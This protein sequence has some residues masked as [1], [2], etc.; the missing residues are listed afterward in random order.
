MYLDNI[1]EFAKSNKMKIN[2]NKTKV[3]KF[4]RA[5]SFDFPLEVSLS[6]KVNLEIVKNIKLLGI[7]ISDKLKWNENT[8]YFCDKARRKI[9]LIRNMKLSGLTENQLLH[10]Y[11]KEVRSLLELA[12]PV[13][14]SGLTIEQIDQIE[15]V[16]KLALS[17]ILGHSYESYERA[18]V[19][20][21]LD[22]L[23]TRRDKLCTKFIRKNL[24]S[25]RPLFQV[26]NK[27]HATRSNQ[28]LLEEIHCRTQA[29]FDSGLPYLTR[30]WNK[31]I[32]S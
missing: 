2:N 4:T 27:T 21:K 31:N 26:K 14:S 19:K 11:K 24:K 12:V 30:L 17:A 10:A 6:D 29:F 7:V 18:L 13:W 32:K 9:W 22:R 15:R 23:S 25:D 5:T 28:N 8:D 16:Q 3:M 20:T 1:E